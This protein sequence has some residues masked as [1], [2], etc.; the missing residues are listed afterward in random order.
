M[1]EQLPL[2]ENVGGEQEADKH[3][4][5]S[6]GVGFVAYSTLQTMLGMLT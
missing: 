1:E 2:H 6:S 5:N 4:S 3:L